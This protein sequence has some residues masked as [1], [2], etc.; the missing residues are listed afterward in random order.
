MDSLNNDSKSLEK[1]V[2]SS[3]IM[4]VSKTAKNCDEVPLRN[5]RIENKSLRESPSLDRH[6]IAPFLL[7]T[8]TPN[9]HLDGLSEEEKVY[10]ERIP[11]RIN[12]APNLASY[13]RM[14]S[15]SF[16]SSIRLPMI[17]TPESAIDMKQDDHSWN[18]LSTLVPSEEQG[19]VTSRSLNQP[20]DNCPLPEI[21]ENSGISGLLFRLT[22]LIS[23]R[24][25]NSFDVE[26]LNH[27]NLKIGT[28][29]S[30]ID[31][32][33]QRQ[34]DERTNSVRSHTRST[35]IGSSA[36][37]IPPRQAHSFITG[38]IHHLIQLTGD[39]TNSLFGN[40]GSRLLGIED[41]MMNLLEKGSHI[42]L[43]VAEILITNIWRMLR[44]ILDMHKDDT[45]KG[46]GVYSAAE[47]MNNAF[48]AIISLI[49]LGRA[50]RNAHESSDSE[51]TAEDSKAT[52]GRLAS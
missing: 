45:E 47:A 40:L 8:P 5:D 10:Q 30:R 27:F 20:G 18:N 12:S 6:E 41:R 11:P 25:L 51:Y 14:P 29:A 34:D 16:L 28:A 50:Y 2:A 19:G 49:H 42:V 22:S 38:E 31:M 9:W 4:I 32:W 43:P 26:V 44:L 1:C 36:R 7:G 15:S 33:R 46:G 37:F 35:D 24:P 13:T 17:R 21:A 23:S 48:S 52:S 3:E 39:L